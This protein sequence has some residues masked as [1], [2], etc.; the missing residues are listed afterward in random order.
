MIDIDA[1]NKDN[2][3]SLADMAIELSI[4]YGTPNIT[5]IFTNIKNVNATN[6]KLAI[7]QIGNLLSQLNKSDWEMGGWEL[8]FITLGSIIGLF[9]IMYLLLDWADRV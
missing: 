8:L 9:V 4:K 6:P 5:N 1:I 7:K 2:V 3:T